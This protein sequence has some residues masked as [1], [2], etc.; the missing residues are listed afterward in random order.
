MDARSTRRSSSGRVAP[1][2]ERRDDIPILA[3]YFCDLARRRL[4]LGPVRLTREAL[5]ALARYPW[6]GNV[7]ELDN[8]LSRVVLRAS[9]SVA[10]GEPV[11]VD[12]AV[13]GPELAELAASPGASGGDVGAPLAPAAREV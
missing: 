10:R 13:L 2:R 7:R 1:L 5:V 3:G 6:P 12:A 9:A 8:V 4:G 11:V